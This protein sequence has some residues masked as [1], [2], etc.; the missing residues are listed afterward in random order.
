MASKK[1]TQPVAPTK[2][3]ME[4]EQKLEEL[5]QAHVRAMTKLEKT[6]N[7]KDDLVEAVYR[8]VHDSHIAM[9]PVP[10]PKLKST[11]ASRKKSAEYAVAVLSDWQLGKITPDYDSPTCEK[12]VELYAEKVIELT[13]IQRLDHPVNELRVWILGDIVEGELIFPGQSY[14]IDSSLYQQMTVDG[15]RILRNFLRSMLDEFEHIHVTAVIGNH[16]SLGG[17]ARRDY[18]PESNADR[19]LY[20]IVEQLFENETR[21]TWTIPDNSSG[22]NGTKGVERNWYAIDKVGAK[23]ALLF[24]GDQVRGGFAGM[25]WYGFNKKVLGWGVGAVAD[26]FDY[27]VCGHWHQ[28]TSFVLNT[29]LVYVNGS[30]ESTNTYAQEQL[31]AVGFPCQWLFFM[32]PENGIT[33]EYRVWLSD[34]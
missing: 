19:V 8:A 33:A 29:K 26:H 20:K 10:K 14:L 4:L 6:K 16:G 25:P 31:A 32:H 28:P 5:R 21:I 17:R 12:R 15:P 22:S 1:P 2:R 7:S 27:A 23:S 34:A 13:N 18:N 24:H 9:E 11:A 30:T 3:E